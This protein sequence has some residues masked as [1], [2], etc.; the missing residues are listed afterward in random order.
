MLKLSFS[1]IKIWGLYPFEADITKSD[2]PSPLISP[3]ASFASLRA[4]FKGSKLLSTKSSTND[5]SFARVI[6]CT[7]C[8]GPVLSAVI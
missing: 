1:A 4:S 3:F 6:F 2:K 5:S 8:F 7:K